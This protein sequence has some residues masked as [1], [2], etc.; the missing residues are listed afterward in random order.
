M[1]LLI[2]LLY[3][4]FLISHERSLDAYWRF[5]DMYVFFLLFVLPASL[6]RNLQCAPKQFAF[7]LDKSSNEDHHLV[8]Q[9]S[10]SSLNKEACPIQVTGAAAIL[11]SKSSDGLGNTVRLTVWQIRAA[12]EDAHWL[13]PV[14]RC[15]GKDCLGGRR[16]QGWPGTHW[17]T[18]DP[19]WTGNAWG[20]NSLNCSTH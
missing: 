14:W 19:I 10:Q 11:Q 13:P 15:S 3:E 4:I 1:V 18:M 5:N 9:S 7:Q 8:S 12:G 2:E 16:P 6:D 17:R 20:S